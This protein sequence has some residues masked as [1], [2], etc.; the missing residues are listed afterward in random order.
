MSSIWTDFVSF[1]EN[2]VWA[3]LKSLFQNTISA[4]VAALTPIVQQVVSTV[5]NDLK[6]ATSLSQVGT[7][8]ASVFTSVAS[9]AEAAAVSAGASSLIT[10]VSS[11]LGNLLSS[12]T[13][14]T[15]ATT[16]TLP[17]GS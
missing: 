15:Q 13:A 10:T 17:T 12:S 7:T 6:S 9:Q 16:P 4:E 14:S 1:W 11:A 2:D 3:G 5:E 8:I